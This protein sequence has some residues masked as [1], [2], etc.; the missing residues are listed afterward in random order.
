MTL[1]TPESRASWQEKLDRFR[2]DG[3]C[4][5]ELVAAQ[6]FGDIARRALR[7]LP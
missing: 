4:E 5:G 3:S 6:H 2:A 7:E 1:L